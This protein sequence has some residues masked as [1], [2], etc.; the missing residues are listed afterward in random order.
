M[1]QKQPN[2]VKDQG[3][4]EAGDKTEKQPRREAGRL[5]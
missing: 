1:E 4:D 5:Q 2:L 3:S